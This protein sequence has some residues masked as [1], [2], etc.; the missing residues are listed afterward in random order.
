MRII[1]THLVAV[2]L[3]DVVDQAKNISEI[4]AAMTVGIAGVS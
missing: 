3:E 2:P 1:I 4:D